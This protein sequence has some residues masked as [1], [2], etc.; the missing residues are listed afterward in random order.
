MI[1]A[2]CGGICL[3]II[4][5]LLRLRQEDHECEAPRLGCIASSRVTLR[6]P[7]KRARGRGTDPRGGLALVK[8][9]LIAALSAAK[10]NSEVICAA[11]KVFIKQQR[12]GARN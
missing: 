9:I 1:Q 6:D 4:S 7:G 8:R 3:F 5:A 11:L 2:R 12:V 10:V